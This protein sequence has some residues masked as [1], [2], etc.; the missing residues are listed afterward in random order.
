MSQFDVMARVRLAVD[1][2]SVA[3]ARK[4]MESALS[5]AKVKIGVEVDPRSITKALSS[6]QAMPAAAQAAGNAAKQAAGGYAT[7]GAAA[8]IAAQNLRAATQAAQ[9]L[10]ATT[11]QAAIAARQLAVAQSNVRAT[12]PP[13][14]GGSG[15]SS[16]T[17]A[18]T[19]YFGV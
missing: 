5:G 16:L 10:I 2:G 4:Q 11:Q 19:T 6:L 12:L 1:N 18:A 17:G 7:L 15:R 9:Q 3:T 13:A 14:V 8:A